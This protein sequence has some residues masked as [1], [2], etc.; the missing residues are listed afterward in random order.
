MEQ[1]ST[2]EFASVLSTGPSHRMLT[3]LVRGKRAQTGGELA[4]SL[5]ESHAGRRVYEVCLGPSN[6][7]MKRSSSSRDGVEIDSFEI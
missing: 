3:R 4:V 5:W 6:P 2:R 7:T 1:R